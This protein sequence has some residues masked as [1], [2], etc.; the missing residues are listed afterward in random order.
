MPPARKSSPRREKSG[1]PS[2]PKKGLTSVRR[3]KTSAP[4]A[5]KAKPPADPG[6]GTC[7]H[8]LYTKVKELGK[9]SFGIIWLVRHNSTKETHVLKEIA[10]AGA[11]DNAPCLPIGRFL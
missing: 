4:S 10:L 1:S 9:G 5:A 11:H 6:L 7:H 8:G 2:P 3:K